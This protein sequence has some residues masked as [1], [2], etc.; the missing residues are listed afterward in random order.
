MFINDDIAQEFESADVYSVP[1]S[2]PGP[3]TVFSPLDTHKV[4]RV[5]SL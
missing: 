4:D 2:I 3:P 1:I 5:T